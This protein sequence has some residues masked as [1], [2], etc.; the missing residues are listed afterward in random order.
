MRR[1]SLL[2]VIPAL[3]SLAACESSTTDGVGGTGS[4]SAST[5]SGGGI[6]ETITAKMGGVL[7]SPDG[8]VTL[9]FQS[10][11]VGDTTEVTL[12]I[13]PKTA[14]TAT[15]IYAFTPKGLELGVPAKLV[16]DIFDVSLPMGKDYALAKQTGATWTVV[17]GTTLGSGT[18]NADISALDTFSVIFVDSGPCD[19]GCMA[20]PGAVCCTGCGCM[21][22]VKCM[23]ECAAPYEWD[24]E[25]ACC[26]DYTAHACEGS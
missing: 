25:L 7:K 15:D 10:G 19:A 8:D 9:T 5:A 4:S 24:C 14:D 11:S 26:Y 21:G 20:A 12:T 13:L 1:S 16:I 18:I 2:L 17:P 3:L 22:E 6:K 23:P